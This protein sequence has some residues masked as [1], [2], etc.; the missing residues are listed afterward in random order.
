MEQLN[1]IQIKRDINTRDIELVISED[2]AHQLM[3]D[4]EIHLKNRTM[5]LYNNTDIIYK[6][7]KQVKQL[8]I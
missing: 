1:R 6:K 5:F 4:L 2:V 8:K 7:L 3:R